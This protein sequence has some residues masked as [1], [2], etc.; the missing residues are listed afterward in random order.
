MISRYTSN[1]GTIIVKAIAGY[2]DI[3][4]DTENI[5]ST[6]SDVPI[7]EYK[8]HMRLSVD[9]GLAYAVFINDLRIGYMV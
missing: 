6:I 7:E 5:I 9:Q 2:T 4:A 8:A 1:V 3:D